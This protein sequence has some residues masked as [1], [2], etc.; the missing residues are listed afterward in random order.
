MLLQNILLMLY[1][2][3]AYINKKTMIIVRQEIQRIMLRGQL[4]SSF[5]KDP[6]VL[7]CINFYSFIILHVEGIPRRRLSLSLPI[8]CFA[9]LYWIYSNEEEEI[10]FFLS[11]H[12]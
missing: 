3:S 9:R 6:T 7:L 12:V 1:I 4:S 2:A 10:N 5:S 8:C 11:L